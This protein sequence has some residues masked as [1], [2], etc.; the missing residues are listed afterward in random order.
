MRSQNEFDYFHMEIVLGTE[1]VREWVDW[2]KT[3]GEVCGQSETSLH[4]Q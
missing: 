3:V 2:S 1:R 4:N